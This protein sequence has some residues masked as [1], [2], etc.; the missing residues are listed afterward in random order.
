MNQNTFIGITIAVL[1]LIVGAWLYSA[2]M[3]RNSVATPT[4]TASSTQTQTSGTPSTPASPAVKNGNTYKS[5][6]TQKGNY[7]C[8]YD[9]VSTS[10]KGHNVIYLSGGKLR[11]EFRTTVGATPSSNLSVYDGH[12]LYT[13][14][15]GTTVGTKS[16][17]T[18]LGQ[19]PTAIPKDLTSGA[20]YG[21]NYNS[22]GWQC[23]VWLLDAKLLTPP[24]YVTFK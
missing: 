19:L 13:W 23:H 22:V 10:G 4:D 14:R 24:S 8:D 1:L 21:E 12:Y 5:L 18:S 20:I 9:Q 3:S 15:E 17:V 2:N 6:L 7:Q 16:L 11:A